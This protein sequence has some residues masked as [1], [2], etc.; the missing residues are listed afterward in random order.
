MSSL[1]CPAPALYVLQDPHDPHDP[2]EEDGRGRP[3]A[4]PAPSPSPLCPPARPSSAHCRPASYSSTQGT[5]G[6]N[7]RAGQSDIFYNR[8]CFWA[9]LV[10]ILIVV[11]NEKD[12][13][14]V[15]D[16]DRDD[17]DDND[18]TRLRAM[19]MIQ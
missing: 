7:S 8:R 2:Q 13:Y 9:F 10:I 5:F 6:V 11:D 16:N 17:G 15:K 12:H 4:P 1:C 19:I 18:I 14:G 3:D